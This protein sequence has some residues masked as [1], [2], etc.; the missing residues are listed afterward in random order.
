MDESET[1]SAYTGL[2]LSYQY[3]FNKN[4]AA[5][6]ALNLGSI[7]NYLEDGYE[8]DASDSDTKIRQLQAAAILSTNN[9]QGWQFYTG[10]GLFTETYSSSSADFSESYTGSNLHFGFGYSG[11]TL[12]G[13][14]RF[15]VDESGDYPEGFSGSTANLQLGINF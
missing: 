8:L 5:Y 13:H 4:F 3:N 7:E 15:T 14:L 12:Q 10:L 2:G 11:K 9:Y 6:S 1:G